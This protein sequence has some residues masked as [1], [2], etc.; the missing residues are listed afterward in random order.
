MLEFF[1]DSLVNHYNSENTNN[2]IES[3]A[4]SN[5]IRIGGIDVDQ[6]NVL[7]LTNSQTNRPLVKF[8]NNTWEAFNVPGLPTSSMAGKICV[9]VIIKNGYKYEIMVY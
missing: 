7:W 4:G 9:Q 3:I 6:D 5:D 1:R 8:S 2:V